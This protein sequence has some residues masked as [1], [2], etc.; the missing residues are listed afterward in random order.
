MQRFRLGAVDSCKGDDP[1]VRYREV[2]RSLRGAR[3]APLIAGFR[4]GDR[5]DGRWVQNPPSEVRALGGSILAQVNQRNQRPV[6]LGAVKAW[7]KVF[8]HKH[9][10][11]TAPGGGPWRAGEQVSASA[12]GRAIRKGGKALSSDR[13]QLD[14]KPVIFPRGEG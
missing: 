7:H 13:V 2:C 14:L 4:E 6:D 1:D 9:A 12:L 11:L 5:A 10:E 8:V 3:G